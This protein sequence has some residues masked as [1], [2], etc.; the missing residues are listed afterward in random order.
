M[1]TT[2]LHYRGT[3]PITIKG[4]GWI[5]ATQAAQMSKGKVAE[6]WLTS[7]GGLYALEQLAGELGAGFV[8]G[9]FDLHR[10]QRD[11]QNFLL[12]LR[13]DGRMLR[14][15]AGDTKQGGGLWIHPNLAL[16][17]ARWV[18]TDKVDH[19]F[20]A[21]LAEQMPE[22]RRQHAQAAKAKREAE[23]EDLAAGY[24]DVVDAKLLEQLRATDAVQ[25]SAG[26]S[27]ESRRKAL[28][29]L[30][31]QQQEWGTKA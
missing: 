17:F 31:A 2:T 1:S 24:A 6:E 11:R 26:A 12:A 9:F 3:H 22:V 30:V 21:W 19:P 16:P 25:R 13:G 28:A 20:A 4:F 14:S 27:L 15:V 8:P 5:N 18:D 7:S 23:A 29:D 10:V